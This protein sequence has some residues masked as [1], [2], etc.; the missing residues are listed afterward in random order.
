MRNTLFALALLAFPAA[1]QAH[2]ILKE[3]VPAD[4]SVLSD[5][6][7][8]ISMS[9][10]KG[11]RLTAIDVDGVPVT[12]PAQSGFGTTF[13]MPLPAMESGDYTLEWRG[14]SEDGH[15]MKGSLGFTVE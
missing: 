15:A 5:P 13:A 6:P 8:E 4:G 3:S 10:G 1:V 9:F 7:A 14:L 11:M 12:L 2:S